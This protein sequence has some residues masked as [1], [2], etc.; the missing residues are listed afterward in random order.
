[1]SDMESDKKISTQWL[2]ENGYVFGSSWGDTETWVKGDF[3][4]FTNGEW[5]DILYKK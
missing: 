3:N 1:M 2:K 4:F 5:F